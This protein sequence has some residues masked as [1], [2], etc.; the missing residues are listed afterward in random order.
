MTVASAYRESWSFLLVKQLKFCIISFFNPFKFCIVL[1]P[2]GSWDLIIS[3]VQL[4]S[5]ISLFNYIHQL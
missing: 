2:R 4:S 1:F 5:N 3:F